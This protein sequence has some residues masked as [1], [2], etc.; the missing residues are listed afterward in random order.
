M[1]IGDSLYSVELIN[2]TSW[3]RSKLKVSDKY[4]DYEE[5]LFARILGCLTVLET[6]IFTSV[7]KY[8]VFKSQFY[9]S[10]CFKMTRVLLLGAPAQTDAY[11]YKCTNAMTGDFPLIIIQTL[12]YAFRTLGIWNELPGSF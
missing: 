5:A 10:W 4:G 9:L 12:Q 2:G 11:L 7:I 1:Q 8:C 6:E 3:D